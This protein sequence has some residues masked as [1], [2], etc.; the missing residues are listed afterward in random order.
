MNRWTVFVCLLL[1]AACTGASKTDEVPTLMVLDTPTPTAAVFS[2]PTN[3]PL[4]Q[5]VGIPTPTP[6]R[7]N[8]GVFISKLAPG[9]VV[10]GNLD[11]S[12]LNH[13]YLFDG[14]SGDFVTIEMTRQSGAIDPLLTLYDPSGERIAMDD[15]S[16]GDQA[17]LL[18]NIHLSKDGLYSVQ[19]SSSGQSGSYQLHFTIGNARVAIMPDFGSGPATATPIVE[20]L[21]PTVATVTTGHMLED[22]VP[23]IGEL[24]S[25]DDFNRFPVF[26]IDGEV[27]TIGA[28]PLGDADLSLSL[29]VYG[30]T[31]D[32][33][34]EGS[35]SSS[36]DDAALIWPLRVDN[37]GAYVVFVTSETHATGQYSIAYGTG[38]SNLDV[39]RGTAAPNVVN[40]GEIQKRGERDVWS[41]Y[42]NSGDVIM[43]A[44]SP[45]N[46]VFDPILEIAKGND[47]QA[48]MVDD[49][50][51][52]DRNAIIPNIRI[53]ESGLYHLRI[54]AAQ[55]ATT[56]KYT[57]LWRYINAVPTPTPARGI[58]RL[59]TVDDTV[60][61][62][63][64]AFYP[65]QGQAGQQIEISVVTEADNG[66]DP[67]AVLIGPDGSIIAEGDDS[68]NSLNPRFV[69][70]LSEEG[71]YTVRV[72]GYL[73]GGDFELS[74]VALY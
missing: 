43:A 63:A 45:A 70:T 56:G 53:T 6:P 24:K 41:L 74:V 13:V 30:P 49:N 46:D 34:A 71:T 50:S 32:L 7:D 12:A 51:G 1:L 42:L 66:F 20:V 29:N 5:M 37:T 33:V 73:R 59:L 15:N 48:F 57:L 25:G 17:A 26:A 72:N 47:Q 14:T 62:G 35:S 18:R 4:P 9:E 40:E 2:G 54:K 44:V 27:L 52:S 39:M 28:S 11:D 55:A 3:T 8:L 64:Y 16:G 22:H 23:V 31:G 69:M 58:V 38:S 10:E 19:A 60:A 65:F 68:E 67:V 61:D 36:A 21:T